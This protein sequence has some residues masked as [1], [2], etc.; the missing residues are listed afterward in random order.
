IGTDGYACWY[1]IPDE[2]AGKTIEVKKQEGSSFA[3]YDEQECVFYSVA[4]GNKPVILPK[5]GMILFA[6]E[7]PGDVLYYS[8]K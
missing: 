2:K 4:C 6:G 3:V 7:K 5:N 1:K 8:I